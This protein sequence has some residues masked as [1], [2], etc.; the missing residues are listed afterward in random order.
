[1]IVDYVRVVGAI[2][3]GDAPK[4]NV[5]GAQRDQFAPTVGMISF[6]EHPFGGNGMRRPNDDNGVRRIELAV[7]DFAETLTEV[8][9][10]SYQTA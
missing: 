5:L 8:R 9:F 7:D 3:L 4:L 6:R 10:V 2:W 1:M